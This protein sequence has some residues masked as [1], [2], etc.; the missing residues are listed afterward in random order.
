MLVI[1]YHLLARGERYKD[2]GPT[3]L[4]QSTTR[5]THGSPA[6][7]ALAAL[8]DGCGETPGHGQPGEAEG[9][10]ALAEGAD[11]HGVSLTHRHQIGL[12]ARRAQPFAE[13]ACRL[14]RRE[15]RDLHDVQDDRR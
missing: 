11:A 15:D 9:A 10:G 1:A 2:L 8:D 4:D 13:V 6:A 14:S 12:E 3:Y 5:N 7:S